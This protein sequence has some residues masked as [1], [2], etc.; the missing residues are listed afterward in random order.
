MNLLEALDSTPTIQFGMAARSVSRV[1]KRGRK[2]FLVSVRKRY[3][4]VR[5]DRH[6]YK[7]VSQQFASKWA[8][9]SP[10]S[11]EDAR[12]E[13]DVLNTPRGFALRNS[14]FGIVFGTIKDSNDKLPDFIP[15]DIV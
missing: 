13:S 10:Q 5:E 1:D 12:M 7:E 11:A 3:I 9:W 14:I 15:D 6:G 8:D 4:L 2:W